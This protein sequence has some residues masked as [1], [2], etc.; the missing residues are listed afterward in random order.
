MPKLRQNQRIYIIS[1]FCL[2][3][4]R[5]Y[6]LGHIEFD[7]TIETWNGDTYLSFFLLGV[8]NTFVVSTVLQVC[9]KEFAEVT[10]GLM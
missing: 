6:V 7:I 4:D 3:L 9:K 1:L 2:N 8:Y 10:Q 5:V